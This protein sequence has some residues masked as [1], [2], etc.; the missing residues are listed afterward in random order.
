L[1]LLTH[2]NIMHLY[3]KQYSIHDACRNNCNLF[4][5]TS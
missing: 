3:L 1:P 4:S 5:E 2:E